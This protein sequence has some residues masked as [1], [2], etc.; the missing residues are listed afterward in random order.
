MFFFQGQRI[1]I[2]LN[3]YREIC[4]R[5]PYVMVKE[6]LTIIEGLRSYKNKSVATAARS[7][8]NLCKEVNP[9]LVNEEA[10]NEEN[11]VYYGKTK[12]D[13]GVDGIDL[14]KKL[15][16]IPEGINYDQENLLDNKQLKKD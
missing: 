9:T 8:I 1:T 11:K 3:A 4:E 15:E 10:E 12:I 7:I 2:G 13:K 14:L 16:H 6:H 5:I